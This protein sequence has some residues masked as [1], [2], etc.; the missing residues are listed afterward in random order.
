MV[1]Q[2][3][4]VE[5]SGWMNTRWNLVKSM[6]YA[7]RMGTH[8]ARRG[9]DP[10]T[11]LRRGFTLMALAV[12]GSVLLAGL[13]VPGSSAELT[14]SEFLAAYPHHTHEGFDTLKAGTFSPFF[15][16]SGFVLGNGEVLPGLGDVDTTTLFG[17]FGTEPNC[18]LANNP[19]YRVTFEYD[20]VA[21]GV[22]ISCLACGEATMQLSFYGSEGALQEVHVVR[23]ASFTPGHFLSYVPTAPFAEVEIERVEMDMFSNWMIDNVRFEPLQLHRDGFETQVGAKGDRPL[24]CLSD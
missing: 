11:G 19:R 12:I 24:P 17:G 23:L 14:R 1:P 7:R 20:V 2:V 18:V 13:P 15:L 8:R 5:C 22:D 6:I 21:F 10:R 9:Y 16:P 3:S 4:T